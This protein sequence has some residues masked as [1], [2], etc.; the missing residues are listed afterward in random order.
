MNEMMDLVRAADAV[1]FDCDGV[2]VDSEPTALAAWQIVAETIGL[3]H[4]AHE[5]EGFVGK[6][7]R[8]LAENY[9]KES[10]MT[11]EQI[12]GINR[13]A[14]LR[15]AADG[16]P[17]YP[18][19]M[20]LL[21]DLGDKPLAVGTNSARWRLDAVLEACG[22]VDRFAV[23]IAVDEVANPKPAPDIYLAAA[24]KLGVDPT[25]CVVVEDTPTGIASARAAGCRVVALD[26]GYF[27]AD[28]FADADLV[29]PAK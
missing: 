27:S 22:I 2:L 17:T 23:S 11:V 10:G 12:E 9:R 3:G 28:Q 14:F 18:D 29:V 21:D 16:I 8:E 4:R 24:E 26:R 20:A 6:T 15:L 5:A 1:L 19:T 7:D 25:R 13:Q